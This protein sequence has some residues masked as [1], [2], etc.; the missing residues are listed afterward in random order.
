MKLTRS[1]LF[2]LHLIE[3]NN[4][5][6]GEGGGWGGAGKGVANGTILWSK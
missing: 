1:D 5:N 4:L 6:K 2:R 3:K